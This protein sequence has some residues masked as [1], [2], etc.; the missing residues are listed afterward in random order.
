[1]GILSIDNFIPGFIRL[2]MSV[3]AQI[4]S[5]VQIASNS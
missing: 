1:M 4:R 3:M 2:L 5:G